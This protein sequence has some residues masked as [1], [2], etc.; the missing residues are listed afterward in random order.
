MWGNWQGWT[1]SAGLVALCCAW[2]YFISDTGK[3]TAPTA[4]SVNPRNFEAMRV[5][6]PPDD[7][8]PPEADVKD[9]PALYRRAIEA[10]L[11][12]RA[13]Y[14]DFARLGTLDSQS[15]TK[16]EAIDLL[17]QAA[18]ARSGAIFYSRPRELIN[19]QHDKP[20]LEAL[21][22]L[23]RVCIDRLGL[24]NARAGKNDEAMKCYRAG[25]AL[26]WGL[27][28]ERL[29]YDEL[30]LGLELMAKS[31]AG[32]AKIAQPELAKGLAE[33][34]R[35]RAQYVQQRVEPLVRITRALDANIVGT[36]TGD[37][38]EIA[39][40]SNAHM[41]RIEAILALGRLKYFAG[42]GGTK[43]DQI[44]AQ[45]FLRDLAANDGS[46]IIRIAAEAARDLTR[47]QHSMQ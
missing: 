7:A 2:L 29:T 38:F 23:G 9:A 16:L 31:S 36:H 44:N 15:A 34:D 19:Y 20:Q 45:K 27:V 17:M 40:R 13:L 21:R 43:A 11:R 12:D 10:F 28:A 32:M 18:P 3:P 6:E 4:F 35:R 41:W 33:F 37:L 14:E 47:E 22:V 1:I 25:M 24:L 39:K 46:E 42:T 5:P 8:L 26:G 30:A